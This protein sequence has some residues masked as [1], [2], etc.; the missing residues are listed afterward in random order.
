MI[1]DFKLLFL[2]FI[3]KSWWIKCLCSAFW[4]KSGA[5]LT[6]WPAEMEPRG[7]AGLA[8]A[9]CEALH[10]SAFWQIEWSQQFIWIRKFPFF[11]L[12][13]EQEQVNIQALFIIQFTSAQSVGKAPSSTLW[14]HI[15]RR[16]SSKR[17]A[18]PIKGFLGPP[19]L[20]SR[21]VTVTPLTEHHK[22]IV[23]GR[24]FICCS[25][26]QMDSVGVF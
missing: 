2:A 7:A 6:A 24:V 9:C 20:W 14:G 16:A 4:S 12:C 8:V 5:V 22:E 26:K 3:R 1:E 13:Y 23:T 15:W 18:D 17:H 10:P 25:R 21:T 19:G 11:P